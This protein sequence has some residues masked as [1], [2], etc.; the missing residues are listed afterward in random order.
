MAQE[1][2]PL[3]VQDAVNVAIPK[4]QKSMESAA[5]NF[6]G[7]T[8]PTENL[9]VG[10]KCMRTD[11]N[12]TVYKLVSLTP[13]TW[14]SENKPLED[15]NDSVDAHQDFKGATDKAAGERGMLPGP[16]A[17]EQDK[18]LRG[19]GNWAFAAINL[20]Q[21][22]KAYKIGDYAY[23]PS[24]PSWAYLECTKAGTTGAIEPTLSALVINS[25]LTDG[26]ATFKMYHIG[27]QGHPV[28][29]IVERANDTSPAAIWGGTWVK[30]D[31]GR[32]LISAGTYTEGEGDAAQTYTYALGDKGGE[33]KHQLITEELA[34]H[35]HTGAMSSAGGHNH[36]IRIITEG[37]DQNAGQGGSN[38]WSDRT[39]SWAGDHAHT[40]SINATGG[41]VAHNNMQPYQAVNRWQRTA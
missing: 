17:G 2:Y 36:T 28:G 39:T 1:F 3:N 29:D 15:H 8:F 18:F 23:S 38:Y 30:M 31:A 6:S 14:V 20:L 33:A 5:S 24:I 41:N 35:G 10:M 26:T 32:V 19:D 11:A 22:G 9:I 16:A 12:N 21:R 4:M 7:T 34:L 25:A 13:A 40:L 27:L 37:Q